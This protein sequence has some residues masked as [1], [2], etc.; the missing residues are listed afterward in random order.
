MSVY[1]HIENFTYKPDYSTPCNLCIYLETKLKEGKTQE[2]QK[3]VETA[4]C[5]LP[6]Q[7]TIR[8]YREGPADLLQEL[9]SNAVVW[10]RAI[11]VQGAE[12]TANWFDTQGNAC[13][14]QDACDGYYSISIEHNPNQPANPPCPN[15]T[16]TTAAEIFG[17]LLNA[18]YIA[19]GEYS[20]NPADALKQIATYGNSTNRIPALKARL[21]KSASPAYVT[22]INSYFDQIQQVAT[23]AVN[24]NAPTIFTA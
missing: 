11:N 23:Q 8:I 2:V 19:F 16:E 14:E 7:S 13:S 24:C 10:L 21:P 1:L 20:I 6:N 17:T 5:I 9:V 3:I 22:R 12:P 18:K 15:M 4:M